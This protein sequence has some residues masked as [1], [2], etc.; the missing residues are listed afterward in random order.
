MSIRIGIYDFFAY[1]IPGVFYLLVAAFGLTMFGIVNID[2]AQLTD[3][4]LFGFLVLL[5]AGFIVGLLFDLLAYKWFLLFRK[6]NSLARQEDFVIFQKR[7]PW[8]EIK[9]R[10]EDWSLMLQTIKIQ[11]PD[12]T[13]ELDEQ[14]ALH[15][16]MRNISLGLF[17]LSLIFLLV[18]IIVYTHVGNL[19]LAILASA[20]SYLAIDRAA[21]RRRWFYTHIYELFL[22][23]LLV[24]QKTLE[25]KV[26]LK[27]AQPEVVVESEEMV[28]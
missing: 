21:Q 3:I 23:H 18:F 28:E 14:N 19:A 11:I 2:L 7:Y 24:Q 4:S 1:L 22:A 26:E 5:A 16:M 17:L 25:G 27:Q 10:P 12:T 8:L 9:F 13:A 15:I 6:R 20:L